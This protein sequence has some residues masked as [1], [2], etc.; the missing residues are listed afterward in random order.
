MEKA[1]LDRQSYNPMILVSYDIEVFFFIELPITNH[2][3]LLPRMMRSSLSDMNPLVLAIFFRYCE[4]FLF[5][6]NKKEIL[7]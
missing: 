2:F 5:D 3:F 6:Y 4:V 1:F 7:N